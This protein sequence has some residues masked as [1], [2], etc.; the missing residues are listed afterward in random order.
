MNKD[1]FIS[2]YQYTFWAD[3]QVL[4]CARHLTPQQFKLDLGYSVGSIWSQLAHMMAVEHWW[5]TFLAEKRIDLL[6]EADYPTLD[7]LRQQW[8]DVESYVLAY[9]ESVTEQ[10]LTREVKPDFW[11]DD[12]SPVAVW[13]ALLQVANHSTDHRAQTLAGLHKLGAPTV[14]QDYLS[15]LEIIEKQG[16]IPNS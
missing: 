7:E 8:D 2:L 9:L 1:Y 15:Y 5:F 6:D 12:E 4:E 16:R 10:E 11:D 13:Q 3:R 14:A